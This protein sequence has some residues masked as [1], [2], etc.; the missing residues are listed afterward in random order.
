ANV[1]RLR[2]I[3][4]YPGERPDP[5][6]EKLMPPENFMEVHLKHGLALEG[7][8][9]KIDQVASEFVDIFGRPLITKIE[10]YK[11]D[12]ADILFIAMGGEASSAKVIID[13]KRDEGHKI[14]LVRLKMYRPCPEK[15]LAKV[16][17]GR[18]AVGV[19]EQAVANGW[20]RGYIYQDL[21]TVQYRAGLSVPMINFFDGMNGGDITL[22]H[23]EK[24]VDLTIDAAQGKDV[25]EYYWL[26]LPWLYE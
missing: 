10:E 1:E 4:G 14:G 23:I 17:K 15:E 16:L 22:E 21:A 9:D 20:N 7:V 19:L 2:V 18:K 6:H 8:K 26:A 24:A 25:E 12:D 11:T 5:T 3:P 13:K